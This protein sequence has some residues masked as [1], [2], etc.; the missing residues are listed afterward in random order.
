MDS[1]LLLSVRVVGC[2]VFPALLALSCW[3]TQTDQAGIPLSMKSTRLPTATSAC[4]DMGTGIFETLSRTRNS[5]WTLFLA[6][7]K[8]HP[9]FRTLGHMHAYARSVNDNPSQEPGSQLGTSKSNWMKIIKWRVLLPYFPFFFL[10]RCNQRIFF[11]S[12]QPMRSSYSCLLFVHESKK[13]KSKKRKK[14][15][16]ALILM[17]IMQYWRW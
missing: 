8:T 16:N 14:E 7:K 5:I 10:F 13:N 6:M 12:F 9:F 2:T 4:V 15:R 11:Y 3:P 1:W 17:I